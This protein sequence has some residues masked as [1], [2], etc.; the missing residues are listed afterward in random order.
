MN[1]TLTVFS[2]TEFGDIRTIELKGETFFV[3]KDVAEI[4]GYS[5]SRKALFDHVDDEDKMDGV[6]I[7]D[8]IGREQTPVFINESGLYSLIL[9]SKM[10][11]AKKFKRWV[12]SE[13]LPS[14][15]KTGSYKMNKDGIPL[16][17]QVES[18]QVVAD[19]LHMNDASKLLML[20]GFYKGYNIPT[21][22]LPKY[23][24]NGSLEMKS[25]TELLKK[26]ECGISASKFNQLL[27]AKGYLEERERSSTKGNGV[28]KFKALSEKGLEF[29]EN[30]VSPHNQ[31]EAQ[32]YYYVDRFMELFNII[33]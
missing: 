3:G 4:L 6:T 7:R 32:P 29:G 8:S 24:N 33:V 18:L 21:D 28:R 27:L 1:N 15:R 31:R 12:T 10:P 13:V 5:N 20:E 2:N 30:L 19:M 9:S 25:A 11:N 22:F 17:E 14:I 23:E 26:F 16:K